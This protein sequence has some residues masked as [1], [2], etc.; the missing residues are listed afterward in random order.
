MSHSRDCAWMRHRDKCTCGK[1]LWRAKPNTLRVELEQTVIAAARVLLKAAPGTSQQIARSNLDIA[2]QRLED[3]LFIDGPQWTKE[4]AANMGK[5]G[6]EA[7]HLNR[8]QDIPVPLCPKC[9]NVLWFDDH[10]RGRGTWICLK[11]TCNYE[12]HQT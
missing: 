3:F 1:P 12:A 5:A 7:L 8:V 6:F 11:A 2:T 10:G 4:Q 9:G